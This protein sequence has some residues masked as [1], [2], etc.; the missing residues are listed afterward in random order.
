MKSWTTALLIGLLGLGAP[1]AAFAQRD[2][3]DHGGGRWAPAPRS[4]GYDNRARA[5]THAPWPPPRE[6]YGGYAQRA[7][8]AYGRA[9]YPPQPRAYYPPQ[10]RY[11]A[12]LEGRWRRGDFLPPAYRGYAIN[13][14]ARYHLRRPPYGYYWCRNGDDYLLVAAASGLIFEVINGDD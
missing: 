4:R 5:A 3:W 9:Y 14:Y 13:D 10:P 11:A 6:D 12:P 7:P 2:A 1:I 8:P